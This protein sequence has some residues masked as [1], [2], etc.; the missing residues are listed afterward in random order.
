MVQLE[1]LLDH[2]VRECLPFMLSV[3]ASLWHVPPF[4]DAILAFPCLNRE[5]H[6]ISFPDGGGLVLRRRREDL[7]LILR[8]S[9]GLEGD[10]RPP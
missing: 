1:P 3:S 10:I 9:G 5:Y 4:G 7:R 8:F 2:G 6:T